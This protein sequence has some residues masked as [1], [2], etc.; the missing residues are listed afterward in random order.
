MA[1]Q[2]NWTTRALK[3]LADIAIYIADQNSAAAEREGA[4]IIRKVEQLA[5][6]PRLGPVYRRTEDA[7]YREILSEKYRIFYYI[8]PDTETVDITAIHHGARNEPTSF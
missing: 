7:E 6:F 8:R 5:A 3:D 1:F 4:K 2:I